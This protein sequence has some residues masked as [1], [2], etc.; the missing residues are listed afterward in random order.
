MDKGKVLIVSLCLIA[1]GFLF[2]GL[3]PASADANPSGQGKSGLKEAREDLE[4]KLAAVPGFAGI[5]HSDEQG[6]IVVFVED[7]PAKGKVPDSHLGFPVRKEVTGPFR[8]LGV[9]VMDRPAISPLYQ[10]AYDRKGVVRPLVGG[11]SL[12]A[13]AGKRYIYAGTLGVVTAGNE[14]LTNAHVIA[15]NP[16]NN[17]WLKVGTPVIQPGSLDGGLTA[18]NRAG[19]LKKIYPITWNKPVSTNKADAAIASID[20]AVGSVIG[21]QLAADNTNLYPIS[22]TDTVSVGD[23]VRKSG[24]TTGVTTNTVALNNVS[25]WVDYG[26]GKKA[27]FTDQVFVWQPFILGGDSGGVVDKGGKVVGID[28]A[29]GGNYAVV[30]KI[31]YVISGLGISVGP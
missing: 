20:A 30:S 10:G 8:A 2:F 1:V 9:Q 21:A 25:T 7:E 24:R 17:G 26:S 4:Q 11:I 23:V 16:D 3:V 13:L 12:S 31:S 6:Q 28:F 29:S 22:G 18:A 19:A 14:I 27:Y 15:M 5:A